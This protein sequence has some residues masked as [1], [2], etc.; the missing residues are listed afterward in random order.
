MGYVEARK[1][2]YVPIYAKYVK[3][4]KAFAALKE[5]VARGENILILDLDG[6]SLK[7]YPKGMEVTME[8]LI[9]CLEDESNIFGH[10]FVIAALLADIDIEE[11]CGEGRMK[12][13]MKTKK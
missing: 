10:G 9:K 7:E 2:L 12:K 1:K 11:M 5:M 6:P 13:K 8:N 3:E 4:T